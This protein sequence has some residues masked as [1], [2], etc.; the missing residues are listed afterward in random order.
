MRKYLFFSLLCFG[1]FFASF[2]GEAKSSKENTPVIV[3][4]DLYFPSQDIGDNLDL[5]NPYLLP[6]IEL[7]AI[8][9]DCHNEFRN[10]IA[11][12]VS[13]GLYPDPDGPRDP[14]Y[15]SIEQLNYIFNKNIPYGVGPFTPMKSK[16]D[17]MEYIS[18]YENKALILLKKT[19][20]SSDEKITIVSFG[21]LRILAV[22]NNRFPEL[23]KRRVKEI[24][25]SA[26]TSS[27]HPEFLEWNVALDTMAF[28]SVM[29]SGLPIK[30]Y[31]CA[32]GKIKPEDKSKFNAFVKDNNNTYYLLS[33]LNYANNLPGKIKNYI[34]YAISRDTKPGYLGVLDSTLLIDKSVFNRTHNVWETAIWMQVANL[35]LVKRQNGD[36]R[37]LMV[38]E[39]GEGD[40][41][42]EEGMHPCIFKVQDSGIFTYD[43][44]EE[45]ISYIYERANAEQYEDWMNQALPK[46]YIM[47]SRLKLS[48]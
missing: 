12:N 2:S 31:P 37:I 16:D 43:F 18:N 3:I 40:I 9:L 34:H 25:I 32:A 8:L 1:S 45:S 47:L 7:K 26:G 11:L 41:L 39:I 27:N 29:E 35:K 20:E 36:I 6:G 24:H 30:I 44:S 48:N 46:Y 5:L 13:K 14:G 21:S 17:K 28:V 42:F 15:S 22:A 4:T 19:L 23:L 10:K 33:N 38:D